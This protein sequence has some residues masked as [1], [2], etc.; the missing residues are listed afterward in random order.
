[1]GFLDETGET[2][3]FDIDVAREVCR[4]LGV[5]LV[6]L[7]IDWDEKE[8]DLN[9]AVINTTSENSTGLYSY[10]DGVYMHQKLSSTII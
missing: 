8:N 6:T 9:S 5:E 1:M 7:G 3:G 10:I 2:V 4:R